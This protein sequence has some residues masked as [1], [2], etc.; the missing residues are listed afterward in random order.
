MAANTEPI[1][2]KWGRPSIHLIGVHCVL[3]WKGRDLIG[4]IVDHW[5]QDSS[6]EGTFLRVKH[7]NGEPWPVNPNAGAVRILVR[8]EGAES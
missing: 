1:P 3:P 6:P 5:Y 4:E 7:F 2:Y 8:R